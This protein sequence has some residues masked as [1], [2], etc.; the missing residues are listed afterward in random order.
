MGIRWVVM[1]ACVLAACGGNGGGDDGDDD[2]GADGGDQADAGP[3]VE[4]VA[5]VYQGATAPP[6]ALARAA[7]GGPA[8]GTWYASPDQVK[9][10]LTR[11]NFSTEEEGPTVGADLV[12]CEVTYDRAAAAL[13]PLLDCP[14]AIPPG[15]Y[16]GLTMF[17]DPVVE[18]LIDDDANGIYTDPDAETGLSTAAPKGGAAFVSVTS[19]LG[20]GSEQFFAEP[21]VVAE[22]EELSLAV[23]V[24]AVQTATITVDGATL[25]FGD[26]FPAYVFP[27]IGSPGVAQ[28]YTS[29]GTADTYDD[30]AVLAN[31]LRV[32]YEPG[33]AAA[34]LI[35]QQRAG[36]FG[37]CLDG[38]HS[39][40]AY[41]A[42]PADAPPHTDG[43][44]AGGWLGLDE[45]DTLCWAFAADE[46]YET[47][48][49]YLTMPRAAT[50]GDETTV[51]CEET[52]APTPPTSGSTY[53]S[54][55]PAITEDT[56]VT[57]T[58]VAD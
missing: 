28:Y 58:L 36:A 57:L 10:R 7:L 22:G 44:R 15:T 21:L 23:V 43:S 9:V 3:E 45:E 49:N 13:D 29:S 51:R 41:P 14:F 39:I 2:D 30:S 11:I 38:V 1:A 17:V 16:T 55:C 37:S 48:N 53:A 34:Y 4:G 52:S 12:D 6:P 54:G 19:T 47:Y 56:S 50:V 42:D 35:F 25:T 18:I 24:D 32:Y 26:Y 31:I 40:A 5:H 8:D 33:G 20:G 27:S 46:A